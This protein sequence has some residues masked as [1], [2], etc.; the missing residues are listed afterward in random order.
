MAFDAASAST[1]V[2][3]STW[4]PYSIR[5]VITSGARDLRIE[6]WIGQTK[7][8]DRDLVRDPSTPL[9]MTNLARAKFVT[10]STTPIGCA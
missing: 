4:R 9:G 7:Q 3:S 2:S 5:V 6:I 8:R 10:S 1:T